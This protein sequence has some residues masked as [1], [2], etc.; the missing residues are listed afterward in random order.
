MPRALVLVHRG[1]D[2]R[3][4]AGARS[5]CESDSGGVLAAFSSQAIRKHL[6]D[7]GVGAGVAPDFMTKRNSELVDIRDGVST[8][9][10]VPRLARSRSLM[11]N[12]PTPAFVLARA[13]APTAP[14]WLPGSD[15]GSAHPAQ[16]HRRRDGFDQR[17][18]T[19]P[20]AGSLSSGKALA[21]F[22]QPA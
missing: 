12:W 15:T 1:R 2:R 6:G 18:A 17:A 7:R 16:R 5:D 20:A 13:F 11:K 21:E 10:S 3:A 9:P 22:R 19:G 4:L 8:T 14:A